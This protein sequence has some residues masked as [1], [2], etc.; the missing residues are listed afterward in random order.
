MKFFIK[1]NLLILNFT[2]AF[3][4]YY[5]YSQSYTSSDWMNDKPYEDLMKSLKG[6]NNSSSNA[7]SLKKSS[8]RE[9][10]EDRREAERQNRLS[11][12]LRQ[13]S[14]VTSYLNDP[15]YRSKILYESE[16]RERLKNELI[17]NNKIT[18]Y[19]SDKDVREII[20]SDNN[21]RKKLLE[22]IWENRSRILEYSNNSDLKEFILSNPTLREYYELEVK[23]QDMRNHPESAIKYIK[24]PQ[25]T[26]V[27]KNDPE[28]AQ[29]LAQLVKKKAEDEQRAEEQRL[30]R[31]KQEE[32][33]N[34]LARLAEIKRVQEEA[35]RA[36]D[37][38]KKNEQKKER[39][40]QLSNKIMSNLS[41][42]RTNSE[43]RPTSE[44]NS[45]IS[46]N[47]YNDFWGDPELYQAKINCAVYSTETELLKALRNAP[48]LSEYISGKTEQMQNKVQRKLV[49]IPIGKI[50]ESVDIVLNTGWPGANLGEKAR[51]SN[52][53]REEE[54]NFISEVIKCVANDAVEAV[55]TGDMNKFN[56]C[57]QQARE[58][59]VDQLKSNIDD[60]THV[61]VFGTI[62]KYKNWLTKTDSG[63]EE[64]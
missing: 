63:D 11:N 38:Y 50:N 5:C 51:V 10:A 55:S 7:S 19:Y 16:F 32:E 53:V 52:L 48:T 64:Y 58:T 15:D 25:I 22:V 30:L 41:P 23:K 42:K 46:R 21:L 56:E 12:D 13:A 59:F 37:Q 4:P 8:S 33:R 29:I 60:L 28:L 47:S 3:V 39:N 36:N 45:R 31:K 49:S 18:D 35:E 43:S 54:G 40:K 24:D 57:I 1:K 27:I 6:N 20:L 26:E 14:Y 2:L 9:R 61:K 17:H 34:E 62:R 44:N